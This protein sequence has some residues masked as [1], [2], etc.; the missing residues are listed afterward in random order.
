MKMIQIPTDASNV[1]DVKKALP[2]A[3]V[4][5]YISSLI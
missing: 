4:Y 5:I 2:D 1:V 3:H